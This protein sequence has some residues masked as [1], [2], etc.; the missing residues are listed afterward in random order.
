MLKS[1]RSNVV[2]PIT[3]ELGKYWEQPSPDHM[4][5]DDTH[6]MMSEQTFMALK[7]YSTSRPSGVYAGKMWRAHVPESRDPDARI[8]PYL[9][10][11]G[12]T[13]SPNECSVNYREALIV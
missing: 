3:H 12:L 1:T 5:I 10:W 6:A 11:Y 4:T 13:E 2:P 7:N 8:V 9:A